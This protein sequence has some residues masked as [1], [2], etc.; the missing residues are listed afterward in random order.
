M[1]LRMRPPLLHVWSFRTTY[2]PEI[3]LASP[4][5]DDV[6]LPCSSWGFG[7]RGISWDLPP[8]ESTHA[9]ILDKLPSICMITPIVLKCNTFMVVVVV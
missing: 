7:S 1:V 2:G 5:F 9:R 3:H 4:P 8:S 6:Y